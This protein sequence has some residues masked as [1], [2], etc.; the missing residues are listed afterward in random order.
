VERCWRAEDGYLASCS[1]SAYTVAFGF[2]VEWALRL[3]L[4]HAMPG[5]AGVRR[6]SSETSEPPGGGMRRSSWSGGARLATGTTSVSRSAA[7]PACPIRRLARRRANSFSVEAFAV[8]LDE[9]SANA[10]GWDKRVQAELP[11]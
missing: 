8:L 3:H 11:A 4:L 7:I 2:L 5:M 1:G 6:V 9:G 10:G